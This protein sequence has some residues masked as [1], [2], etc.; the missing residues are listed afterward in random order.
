MLLTQQRDAF[1]KLMDF[2]VA[3]P[4][5]LPTYIC[6]F[7]SRRQLPHG[8]LATL[9]PENEVHFTVFYQG[10]VL[11]RGQLLPPNNLA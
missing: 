6:H 3:I 8:H 1:V 4:H 7:P 5:Y 10:N 2:R 9:L 11:G